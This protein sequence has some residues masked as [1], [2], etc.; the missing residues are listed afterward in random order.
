MQYRTLG[1][2]GLK[3]SAMTLGTFTFGGRGGFARAGAQRRRRREEP[4]STRAWSAA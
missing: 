1:R 2:T 4:A 3:V